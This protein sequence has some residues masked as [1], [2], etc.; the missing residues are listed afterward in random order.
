MRVGVPKEIKVHE[1][2]VGMT[3]RRVVRGLGFCRPLCCYAHLTDNCLDR[4][5]TRIL[6]A[7]APPSERRRAALAPQEERRKWCADDGGQAPIARL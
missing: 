2:R 1:Y 5:R 4:L 7:P 6:G 3:L